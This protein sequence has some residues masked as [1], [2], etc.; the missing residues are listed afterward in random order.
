MSVGNGEDADKTAFIR[1]DGQFC[2]HVVSMGLCNSGATFKRLIDFVM[3][4][5]TYETCLAY[6]GN[7]IVF[8]DTADTF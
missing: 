7:I 5:L 6:T 3:S 8:S 4:G 2:F 1:R